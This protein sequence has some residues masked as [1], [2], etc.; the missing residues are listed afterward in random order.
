MRAKARGEA[1]QPGRTRAGV[2]LGRGKGLDMGGPPIDSG[3][4]G[5]GKPGKGDGLAWAER[6]GLR[7][8]EKK[9]EKRER[10]GLGPKEKKGRKEKEN[11]QIYLNLSLKFKFK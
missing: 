5:R 1:A 7:G 3:D 11:K 9:G 10:F 2:W 4:R 6:V 8:R